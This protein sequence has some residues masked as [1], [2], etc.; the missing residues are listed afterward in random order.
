MFWRTI[1]LEASNFVEISAALRP[2]ENVFKG[3]AGKFM[4]QVAQDNF[5]RFC[6]GYPKVPGTGIIPGDIFGNP[7]PGQIKI[8]LRNLVSKRGSIVNDNKVNSVEQFSRVSRVGLQQGL[9]RIKSA[10]FIAIEVGDVG[11]TDM[12]MIL[13][14]LF[15]GICLIQLTAELQIL[16]GNEQAN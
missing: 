14:W 3:F 5:V 1:L 8:D 2:V 10:R 13:G 7:K 15:H 6:I 9:H 4:I 11:E 16:S 12:A